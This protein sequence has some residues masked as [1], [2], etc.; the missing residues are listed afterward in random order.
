MIVVVGVVEDPVPSESKE[1]EGLSGVNSGEVVG[2]TGVGGSLKIDSSCALQKD[3]R[4]L[5]NERKII[6]L[7]AIAKELEGVRRSRKIRR[8][9]KLK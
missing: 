8:G 5:R 2:K 7:L 3:E 9:K 6:V 4:T 1:D